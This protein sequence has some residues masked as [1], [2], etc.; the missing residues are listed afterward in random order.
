MI[1]VQSVIYQQCSRCVLDT[2]D[3]PQ[4]TFNSEGVC[5]YCVAYDDLAKTLKTG[6]DAEKLLHEMVDKI[7]LDGKNKPYDCLI[8]LSG[9]A[10]STYLAFKAK[11]F[12]LRPLAVHFDNGW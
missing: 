1:P 12:G 7:K 5:S 9:G 10:D 4:I 11:E 2:Q 3:D 6:A 8:G